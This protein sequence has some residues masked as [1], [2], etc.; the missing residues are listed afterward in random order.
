MRAAENQ[1]QSQ[2]R[3]TQQQLVD[4]V[5]NKTL[6][7]TRQLIERQS[8]TPEDS[9]CQTLLAD[10]LQAMGF[11]VEHMRFGEVDNLWAEIGSRGPLLV[12][13]GHTDV[14]PAGPEQAWTS[15]PFTASERD[16]FLYGRGA[17]DMKS[18]L[19]AMITA[20]ETFLEQRQPNGRIGFLITSDEE[21][22]AINGTRKVMQTLLERGVQIDYCLVGEPS[23]TT[24][25]GDVVK[26]GRR[27]SLGAKLII[28]GSAGHVAY[29]HLASN[30][31]H[32]AL[33][34]LAAITAE[35]WDQGNESFPATSLQISNL[36][37]G[38][39]ATNVIPGTLEV[40]L[41][42]R[43]STELDANT[44]KQ[45]LQAILD[46]FQLDYSI[47]W[48]LSG[49]PFLTRGGELVG[50]V[51]AGIEKITGL[52]TEL[53]TAGGTSDGRFI[54]PTGAQLVELGPCNATIHKV[55][56]C[57]RIADLESLAAIYR[58]II[59]ELL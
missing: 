44:I 25:L 32:L 42:L 46:S 24:Q 33:P 48:N 20:C 14:V 21:G 37:A 29:P 52:Q 49:E 26:I 41:N 47:D 27:G 22:I 40:D 45:R 31:I 13:A 15:P 56:E 12:F 19:A 11:R 54:A 35:Q 9:G 30:P 51:R 8:V 34:A 7:L 18:S 39:G 58:E 43:Y 6:E 17:A 23:S 2:R 3:I 36:H 50:A 53:S 28:Q 57:V 16:G 1:H 5:M 10:R 38:V 4:P 55:D 59:A